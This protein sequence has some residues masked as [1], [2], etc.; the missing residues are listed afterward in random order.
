M[1]IGFYLSIGEGNE[2][3]PPDLSIG[4][5]SPSLW[6]RKIELPK[7]NIDYWFGEERRKQMME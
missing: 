6:G 7:P 2:C 5:M 1:K 3:K 4:E